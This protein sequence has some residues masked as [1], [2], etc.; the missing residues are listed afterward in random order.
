MNACLYHRGRKALPRAVYTH[1]GVI[2]AV[3]GLTGLQAGGWF[4]KEI[5]SLSDLEGGMKLSIPGLPGGEIL[6]SLHYD[7][8]DAAEYV[9]PCNDPAFGF[10]TAGK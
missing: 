4:N 3:A 9:G 7:A 8:I 6:I 10:Y 1:F 2:P 5:S